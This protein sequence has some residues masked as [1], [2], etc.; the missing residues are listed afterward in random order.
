[1]KLTIEQN[2]LSAALARVVPVVPS[3]STYAA[4]Q[5]VM[6]IAS[7]TLELTATDLD[8]EVRASADATIETQGAVTIPAKMLA[9]VVKRIPKGAVV[10]IDA[11]D[12]IAKVSAGRIKANIGTL[13]AEDF[14]RMASDEYSFQAQI[15]PALLFGKVS[16]AMSTEE[17]KYYLNGVYVHHADGRMASVA[18]DGHRLA[19]WRCDADCGDMPGVIVP[20]RTVSMMQAIDGTVTMQVSENKVRF[21][22]DGWSIV[23]KVVDGQFVDYPRIIPERKGSV[24]RF[25]G[26]AMKAAVDRVG[27]VLDKTSNA[28]KLYIGDDGIGVSGNTGSNS[29]EDFVDA[30][31]DGD[32]MCVAFS[33]KYIVGAMQHLDGNAVCY[34]TDPMAPARIEDDAD[35][36][37]TMVLMPMR[38]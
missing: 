11:A 4:L 37:W 31:L 29:V 3:K 8:I 24:A 35:D 17:M 10:T 15:E 9:E 36:D 34:I 25:D 12:G 1:M 5:N 26:K 23:S 16:F 19:L 21:S 2:T 32:G 20:S 13:P 33:S 27:A 28:V 30:T 6:L 18:T 14:P 38:A 22:A 7:D